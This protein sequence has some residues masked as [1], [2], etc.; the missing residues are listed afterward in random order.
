MVRS[1]HIEMRK[2]LYKNIAKKKTNKQK[3][4]QFLGVTGTR[5]KYNVRVRAS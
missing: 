2:I 5:E 3:S 4:K 1:R